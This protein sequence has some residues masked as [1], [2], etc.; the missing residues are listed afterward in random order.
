M[1]G[2]KSFNSV[3]RWT[4]N[5]GKGGFV[6]A[7]IRPSWSSKHLDTSGIIE[8]VKNEI[9]SRLPDNIELGIE[10]HYDYE[11]DEENAVKVAESLKEAGLYLAMITPGMHAHW[12]YGGIASLDPDERK[13]AE[14][15]VRRTLDLAY[16]PLKEAWHPQV[17]PALVLWNGAFGYD[18]ATIGIKQMYV[19]LKKSI[20]GLCEYEA[21]KGGELYIGLEPKPNE[22]HPAL[23]V[24][25]VASALLMWRKIEEEF[26]IPREKKGVNKE[27]GHSEMIGL[28]HVYDTVEELDD[29]AMVHMHLNSQGYNDGIIL[30]GPGKYD[31]DHG[32][33]INGMNIA[34]AGLIEE[35]GY[36]RW[37]GHDMQVRAYDNVE[38]GLDRVVRSILSWEACAEAAR[39]LDTKELMSHLA[40]RNTAKAEDMIWE[41]V[42]KAH[43]HFDK[44]YQGV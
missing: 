23:L 10:L 15:F 11:V 31:I 2:K 38:Q 20:A 6:P 30:G 9:A 42:V 36:D 7:D 19:A 18:L 26:G 34:I 1:A 8:L 40:T 12:A 35:A 44:T 13:E 21:K 43:H 5:P 33:R 39:D 24:P 22:G 41:A 14:D 4:F 3:C 32:V 29:K 37:K 27:F 28:D 16:G 25:T 17:P